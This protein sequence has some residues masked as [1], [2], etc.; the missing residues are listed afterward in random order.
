MTQLTEAARLLREAGSCRSIAA[1]VGVNRERIRRLQAGEV[2][3]KPA[4]RRALSALV[5]P[6]A[7]DVP[8]EVPAEASGSSVEAGALPTDAEALD[9]LIATLERARNDPGCPT[10]ELASI[11][12]A[13]L[14]ARAARAALVPRRAE[15][16]DESLLELVASS[17]RTFLAGAVRLGHASGAFVTRARTT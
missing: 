15:P 5:P 3:P 14:R 8:A 7:W 4:E 12:G 16:I 9:A 1:R 2:A 10:R 6:S 13:E 11:A 17:P